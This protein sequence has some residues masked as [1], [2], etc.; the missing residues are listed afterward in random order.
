[1]W[2][3]ESVDDERHLLGTDCFDDDN[4]SYGNQRMR[5]DRYCWFDDEQSAEEIPAN[6]F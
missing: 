3:F 2:V 6:A 1:M 4:G 5:A